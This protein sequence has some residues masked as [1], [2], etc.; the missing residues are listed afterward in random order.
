[1]SLEVVLVEDDGGGEFVGIR[2]EGI[3]LCLSFVDEEDGKGNAGLGSS[4]RLDHTVKN[5]DEGD[6]PGKRNEKGTYESEMAVLS[7]KVVYPRR[8]V[9]VEARRR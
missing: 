9:T 2:V 1:M 3:P 7:V 5:E 4:A 8:L 6:G